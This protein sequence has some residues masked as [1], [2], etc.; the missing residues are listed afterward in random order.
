MNIFWK[1]EFFSKD[2]NIVF[3]PFF[4]NPKHIFKIPKNFDSKHYL[5]FRIFEKE[6]EKG[7]QKR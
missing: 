7:K 2:V 3:N 5:N 1:H 4:E 6:T